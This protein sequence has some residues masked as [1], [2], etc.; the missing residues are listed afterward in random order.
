MCS[1]GYPIFP[2]KNAD[3]R[4]EVEK[5]G[6]EKK[7]EKCDNRFFFIR[8]YPLS[9]FPHFLDHNVNAVFRFQ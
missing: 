6:R 1:F 5:R 7:W 9:H 2:S 8:I 4:K 3:Y